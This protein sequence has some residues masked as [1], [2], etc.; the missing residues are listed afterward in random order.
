MNA[1]KDM[2]KR[3]DMYVALHDAKDELAAAEANAQ[4]LV[5]KV[6]ADVLADNREAVKP[7]LRHVRDA[8]RRLNFCRE[9]LENLARSAATKQRD[10]ETRFHDAV[11]AE[12]NW[13]DNIADPQKGIQL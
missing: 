1:K 13:R 7:A 4:K 2:T 8:I 12:F 10:L 9:E 11:Y 3:T 6:I 5:E